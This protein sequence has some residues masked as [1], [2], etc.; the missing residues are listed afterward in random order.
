[1]KQYV[2]TIILTAALT[3][4]LSWA[5]WRLSL[6]YKLHPG[7]RER[8]VHTTPTPRLGGI[9]MF[10]GVTAAFLLSSANPFFSLVWAQP[11]RIWAILGAT[12]LIVIVGVTVSLSKLIDTQFLK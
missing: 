3:F 1:M 2:F 11:E 4:A 10:L 12:T 5:V 8:D 7:I 6:R 9:A